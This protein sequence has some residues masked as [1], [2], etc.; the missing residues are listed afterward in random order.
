M[1]KWYQQKTTWTALA[2]VMTALGGY[3][4]DEISFVTLIG[5]CFAAMA[6]IFGRQGVEKSGV[7]KLA[8]RGEEVK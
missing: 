7:P 1:R 4:T 8:D 5:S 2:G 3:V 6:V